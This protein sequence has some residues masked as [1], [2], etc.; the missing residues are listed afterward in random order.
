MSINDTNELVKKWCNNLYKEGLITRRDKD[1]CLL[2]EQ[3]KK[4]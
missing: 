2:G 4:N 3:N 1:K